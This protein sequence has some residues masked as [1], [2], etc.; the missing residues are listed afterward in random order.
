M[1]TFEWRLINTSQFVTLNM[2]EPG[3]RAFLEA[4]F[5]AVVCF[6][7]QLEAAG[8]TWAA[9]PVCCWDE[10]ISLVCCSWRFLVTFPQAGDSP[11]LRSRPRRSPDRFSDV[12]LMRLVDTRWEGWKGHSLHIFGIPGTWSKWLQVTSGVTLN[13]LPDKGWWQVMCCFWR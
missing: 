13:E 11:R 6:C 5:P 9:P 12:C 2:V 10:N 1:N 7:P 4:I 8:F 3:S